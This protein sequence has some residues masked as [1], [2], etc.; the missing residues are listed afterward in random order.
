M[1]GENLH[2]YW[3]WGGRNIKSEN[4]EV[5]VEARKIR[6]KSGRENIKILSPDDNIH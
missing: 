2:F 1:L 6:M 4:K 5:E 3:T